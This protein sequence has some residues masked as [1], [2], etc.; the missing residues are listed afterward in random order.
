MGKRCKERGISKVTKKV[1]DY[2]KCD[3]MEEQMEKLKGYD[4]GLNDGVKAISL[5]NF[6]HEEYEK[7]AK[8]VGWKTQ[9]YCQVKFEELP[10]TNQKVMVT[11]AKKVIVWLREQ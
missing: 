6:M 11:V 8:K 5:A 10:I 9:K 2:L 4:G 7:E 3:I 1:T